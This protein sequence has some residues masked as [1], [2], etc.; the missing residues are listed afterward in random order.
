MRFLLELL[1]DLGG[2][3]V[4]MT[5]HD[6]TR[7][8][9]KRFGLLGELEAMGHVE[10][11]PLMAYH[12]FIATM[13]GSRF[14]V[15]DG[16]GP[17]Q[18]SFLLGVPCLILREKVEREGFPNVWVSGYD[19]EKVQQFLK[20]PERFRLQVGIGRFEDI[21]PSRAVVDRLERELGQRRGA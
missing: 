4:V 14:V 21:Q 18:E 11:V 5:L 17:Q 20:E 16:G 2:Q 19:R 9:L 12:R 3:R 15:T 1:R 10:A 7:H 6:S 13:A 8:A